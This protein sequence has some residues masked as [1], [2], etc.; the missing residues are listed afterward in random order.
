MRHIKITLSYDGSKFDGSQIQDETQNTVHQK[1]LDALQ[2][3]SISSSKLIFSGRTDK[4]VH[5]TNQVVSTTLPPYWTNLTKLLTL[6]NIRLHPF[7]HIKSIVFVDLDFHARYS[8]KKRLY[9]YIINTDYFNPFL[10]NYN[11]FY[12][13]GI[14]L[15]KL[16]QI[17]NCFKGEHDFVLFSKK[18]SD[19]KS[20]I[21]NIYDIKIYS[22]KKNIYIISILGNS[23]LRSQV[24]LI[25]QAML[26][27]NE[28]KITKEQIKEQLQGLKAHITRLAPPSGLYLA[29]IFYT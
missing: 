16:S 7:I 21:R 13:Y 14:D 28:D 24:R 9:R 18:G 12:S 29:K 19:P 26:A 10:A 4:N 27:F 3:L 1:L 11:H 8:A 17:A 5:A 22:P 25:V 20:T 2:S 15:N 23:F 6:L